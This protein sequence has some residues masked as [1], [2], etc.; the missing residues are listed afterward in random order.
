VGCLPYFKFFPADWLADVLDLTLAERGAYITFLAWSWKK[1]SPLPLDEGRRAGIL[2]V[3]VRE[4]RSVWPAL[5]PYWQKTRKGYVNRRLESERKSAKASHQRRVEAGRRGGLARTASNG[6][7][8]VHQ[9][10][11]AA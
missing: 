1:E 5:E 9:P 6:A 8:A 3:Q 4:L 7:A 2:G 11:D 10:G